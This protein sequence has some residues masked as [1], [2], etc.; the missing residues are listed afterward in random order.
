MK[1]FFPIFVENSKVPVVLS[2]L[3]PIDIWAISLGLFVFCRGEMSEETKNHETIHYRQWVELLFIGFLI[4]YPLFWIV[5]L[6]KYRNGAYA[7]RM[8]PFEQEAYENDQ[9]L[10][11]LDNRKLYSWVKYVWRDKR[12]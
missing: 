5:G 7:Y 8:I 3:S 10:D 2:K 11:Y 9:N 1:N 12:L 6:I 4:L